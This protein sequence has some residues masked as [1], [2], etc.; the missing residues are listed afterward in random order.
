M[1]ANVINI[2][3]QWIKQYKDGSLEIEEMTK[4]DKYIVNSA[5]CKIPHILPFDTRYPLILKHFK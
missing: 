4:R 5:K 1:D 2:N 3:E